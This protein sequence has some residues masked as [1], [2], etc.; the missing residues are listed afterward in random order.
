MRQSLL[1]CLSRG[2]PLQGMLAQTYFMPFAL[3]SLAILARMTSCLTE[4]VT[5]FA[6]AFSLLIAAKESCPRAPSPWFADVSGA[7][8]DCDF[9]SAMQRCV[10]RRGDGSDCEQDFEGE[11]R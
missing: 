5:N 8:L 6:P 2:S 10:N 4:V 9:E 11:Q 3:T 1:F 7:P